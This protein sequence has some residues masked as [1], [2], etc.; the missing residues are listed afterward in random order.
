MQLVDAFAGA[1]T[2]HHGMVVAGDVDPS[3]RTTHHFPFS[4]AGGALLLQHVA[5]DTGFRWFELQTFPEHA[6]LFR[7]QLRFAP[8][9]GWLRRGRNI[10]DVH[11]DPAFAPHCIALAVEVASQVLAR[12]NLRTDDVDLL[13][14]SQYPPTFATAVAD[15]LGLP[16]TRVPL[17]LDELSASHTAGPLA[18]LEAAVAS[19]QL[20]R[21]RHVLFVT[22]G[23]GIT[24]GVALYTQE[25]NMS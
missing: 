3:P 16:L 23:A 9:A 17:V 15:R 5:G 25:G 20:E 2:V 12:E 24:I 8:H 13:I 21:A 6:S 7:V 10:I 4:P 14:A 1:G 22:A 11:E 19:H 18:A